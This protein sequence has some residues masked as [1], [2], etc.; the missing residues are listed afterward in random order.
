MQMATRSWKKANKQ[1]NNNN[2]KDLPLGA[3]EGKEPALLT[4]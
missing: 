2:T 4:P 3:S 1:T